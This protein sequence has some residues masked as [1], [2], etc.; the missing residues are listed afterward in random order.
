MSRIRAEPAPR[1]RVT[2][3][4]LAVA[5]IAALG[6]ALL[7]VPDSERAHARVTAPPSA[8][9]VVTVGTGPAGVAIPRGFVGFS[10][11]YPALPAYVGANPR[12]PNPV[13]AQLVRNVTPGGAS[14]I[15][16]G[17]DSTDATWWPIRGMRRPRGITYSLTPAWMAAAR[18]LADSLGARLI[19]GIS[20][21]VGNPRISLA[22]AHAL[23]RGIG[24][25]RIAALEIG[26]EPGL[27]GK[28]PFYRTASGRAVH[29]RPR[30]YG[31]PQFTH[32]FSA[33]AARLPGVPLAGPTLGV[34]P[35]SAEL[36]RFLAAEPGVRVATLH[37]YPL[38]RCFP[39]PSS[40]TYA[41]VPHLLSSFAGR[42]LVASLGR[43]VAIARRA[44]VPMQIDELNSVSCSGKR[45][46]SDTFAAALWALDE[47]FGMAAG[48]V[49]GVNF[50]TF[51]GAG[52]APFAFA[53]GSHGWSASVRPMY[54]GLLAFAAAAPP[55]A[56]LLPVT[57]R[58]PAN[59]TAWA[60]R[61]RDRRLRVVLINKALAD[62]ARVRL[63]LGLPHAATATVS[64]LLAPGPAARGGVSLGGQ[65]FGTRTYSGRLTG[66]ARVGVI[67]TGPRGFTV[68]VPAAS[69]AVVTVDLRRGVGAT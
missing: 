52:Y 1:R 23:L 57:V 7:N 21:K 15:R 54:Y 60:T 13:F 32:E 17:G 40:P 28:F 24:R 25:P 5:A 18:R 3:R 46:V 34:P 20:L 63:R 30:G 61:A 58:S 29:A 27:Y 38:N 50:H 10:L 11:E 47:L 33:L 66:R 4:A 43:S 49:A 48:H 62:G 56:R 39:V 2:T 67:H 12:R 14:T 51:P 9:A 65:S 8:P 59:L 45:G 44:G 22:E 53:H 31:L 37:R 26:N 41:T 42:G 55:G 69:A 64:R 68:T 16:I 35:A 19:L 36:Q 6:A